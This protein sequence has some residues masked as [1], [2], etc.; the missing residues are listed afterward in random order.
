MAKQQ[1]I[2]SIVNAITANGGKYID[3]HSARRDMTKAP[4]FVKMVIGDLISICP[5][6]QYREGWWVSSLNQLELVEGGVEVSTES[7]HM[8][9]QRGD[10]LED[11]VKAF[12]SDFNNDGAAVRAKIT[13]IWH[14]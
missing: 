4:A 13:Q 6:H 2:V 11:A 10:T 3:G 14:A 9:N 5:V 12:N 1:N 8:F 7:L